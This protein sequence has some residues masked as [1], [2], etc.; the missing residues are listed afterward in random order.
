MSFFKYN[1]DGYVVRVENVAPSVSSQEIVELFSNLIGD[2]DKCSGFMGE[3]NRRFL[4]LSFSSQDA[5]KKAL[6]MTGYTVAG[7]PLSVS[8]MHAIASNRVLK[9][10]KQPD[11]RRN[12]YVLGLPFDLTKSELVEIFSRYGAV[13]HA[14]ILATVDNASRRRGFI[15][16]G[17]HA[18]ARIAMEGLSRKEIKG[19]TIDVS[20]A[21][22]Q[23][24]QGFLDGGDR[25]VMLSNPSGSP[26]T[27]P[28][29]DA[30][31][32]MSTPLSNISTPALATP[33][34]GQN[35]PLSASDHFCASTTLLVTNLPAPL[36]SSS[37][38]L[39]PLLCPFGE[40]KH[41][42]I[43]SSNPSVLP[44][45]TISVIVEYTSF[46]SARDARDTLR[47]QVYANQPLQVDFWGSNSA[48]TGIDSMDRGST[49]DLKAR[50][51]PHAPP[52]T[53]NSAN[54]NDPTL[55]S[56]P[57][58]R[59]RDLNVFENVTHGWNA[60]QSAPLT[61]VPT[62][63]YNNCLLPPPVTH[64]PSSA[65]SRYVGPVMTAPSNE[66]LGPSIWS[67]EGRFSRAS[68]WSHSSHDLP[69]LS[70]PAFN[71]SYLA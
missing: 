49:M 7:V 22:V 26:P 2:V 34:L 66:Q 43:L 6:C 32:A 68:P 16:M 64:R 37:S 65:P 58:L 10:N 17:T 62:T 71:S 51:N 9:H 44:Q 54:F 42:K 53:I 24:S 35:L 61:P 31:P 70:S 69:N 36:F 45:G 1:R 30:E 60:L 47:G 33:L 20:W 29:V 25:T 27:S 59:Q 18:E 13:A 15:V 52:F 21:V 41:V 40:V 23:R 48:P 67:T 14:V 4:E 39:Y 11:N 46:T 5:S 63:P 55:R 38:D 57:Y 12:L 56:S 19:H 3:G 28:S 8:P 50:L